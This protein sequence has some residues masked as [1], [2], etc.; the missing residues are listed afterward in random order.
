MQY[1]VGAIAEPQMAHKLPS[2][3]QQ[4]HGQGIIAT[5]MQA[6]RN[7]PL[8]AC[9]GLL[10]AHTLGGANALRQLLRL[11]ELQAQSA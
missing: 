6:T 3:E 1:V 7:E 8:D 9:T 10:T 5:K 4:K 2:N 11:E